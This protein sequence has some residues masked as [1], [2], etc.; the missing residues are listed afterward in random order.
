[1]T[2]FCRSKATCSKC[3]MTNH[4][5]EDCTASTLKCINCK[6][7]HEG[8]SKDCPNYKYE[9]EICEITADH[10]VSFA[11]AREMKKELDSRTRNI[12]NTRT[13]I[14]F[15]TQDFPVLSQA[16]N[17]L[18]IGQN[19]NFGLQRNTSRNPTYSQ[20][21]SQQYNTPATSENSQRTKN[22]S[23]G[24]NLNINQTNYESN[25]ILQSRYHSNYPPHQHYEN[26]NSTSVTPQ[27]HQIN[28]EQFSHP[29]ESLSL[30][31]ENILRKIPLLIPLI[32]QIIYANTADERINYL[33]EI[34]KILSIESLIKSALNSLPTRPNGTEK[35]N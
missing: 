29:N 32:I 15:E 16:T 27:N 33:T 8:S 22:K 17:D 21:V 19:G 24:T 35:R 1:M 9:Q 12:E 13:E 34:G 28:F 30:S 6:G 2:K 4:K 18:L 14:N 10:G 23:N 20:M 5:R 31:S 11:R 3:T 25:T 26:T 7:Q